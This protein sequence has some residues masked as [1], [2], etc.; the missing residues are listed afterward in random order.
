M[1]LDQ[2]VADRI[3][4]GKNHSPLGCFPS[5]VAGSYI[6][7][8]PSERGDVI[9][10]SRPQPNGRVGRQCSHTVAGNCS[11]EHLVQRV[12]FAPLFHSL[13]HLVTSAGHKNPKYDYCK[14]MRQMCVNNVFSFHGVLLLSAVLS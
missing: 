11:P 6:Q 1:K 2:P 5:Q 13:G 9:S 8:A 12:E 4:F 10:A 7:Q 14:N 3:E